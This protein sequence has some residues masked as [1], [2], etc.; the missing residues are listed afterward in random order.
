[1]TQSVYRLSIISER[2]A[3]AV[4]IGVGAKKLTPSVSATG[5]NGV[6][7]GHSRRTQT[8]MS[9]DRAPVSPAALRRELCNINDLV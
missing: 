2:C 8:A 1:M 3:L 9:F 4:R 5:E 7:V 6:S